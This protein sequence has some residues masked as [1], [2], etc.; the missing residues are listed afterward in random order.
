[1]DSH[2]DQQL[3]AAAAAATAS[4][5]GLR[6]PSPSGGSPLPETTCK[7]QEEARQDD[8]EQEP[9]I[10]SH[11]PTKQRRTLKQRLKDAIHRLKPENIWRACLSHHKLFSLSED[12]QTFIFSAPERVSV[13]HA[14]LWF[15]ALI[16]ALLFGGASSNGPGEDRFCPS[17]AL[18]YSGTHPGDLEV[19]EARCLFGGP[20]VGI[21]ILSAVLTTFTASAWQVICRGRSFAVRTAKLKDKQREQVFLR[22]FLGPWPMCIFARA[23]AQAR[24][25]NW[26]AWS[27]RL[28]CRH[29]FCRRCAPQR[30]RLRPVNWYP[31]YIPASIVLAASALCYLLTYFMFHFSAANF[32][33][34]VTYSD[35]PGYKEIFRPPL[36]R[37]E[38]EA[39]SSDGFN[40]SLVLVPEMQ[41]YMAMLI[42]AW[43]LH[44]FV[45]E[46]LLLAI[47]LFIGEPSIDEAIYIHRWFLLQLIQVPLKCLPLWLRHFVW[48]V[49][50]GLWHC[51]RACL[52]CLLCCWCCSRHSE[53]EEAEEDIEEE[54]TEGALDAGATG[55]TVD[56][57]TE[58]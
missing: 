27:Y 29:R 17:T 44:L 52:Y 3:L 35:R 16:L 10:S 2:G 12:D 6:G 39:V 49:L 18:G 48:E 19:A 7:T 47:H 14:S 42:L 9:M 24:L 57:K 13:F 50:L 11:E 55:T 31:S 1:M 54:P 32:M 38:D 4:M 45:F 30:L 34:E 56:S 5:S 40:A 8:Q 28:V 53:H 15:N 46:P 26:F 20:A 23:E 33:L 37:M 43:I 25:W 21:S 51:G 36:E 22:H 58:G 41:R